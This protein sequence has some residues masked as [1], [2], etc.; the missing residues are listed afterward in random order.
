MEALREC[1]PVRYHRF[2]PMGYPHARGEGAGSDLSGHATTQL[3]RPS[4]LAAAGSGSP[5]QYVDEANDVP[6]SECLPSYRSRSN[7]QPV[8]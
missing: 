1:I 4:R 7:I 5:R 2:I 3:P 6:S 8:S